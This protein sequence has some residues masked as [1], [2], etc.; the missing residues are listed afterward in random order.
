MITLA[1]AGVLIWRIVLF[2]GIFTENQETQAK[3]SQVSF[4][5]DRGRVDFVYTYQGQRYISGI[6][7]M[8][9]RRTKALR[10]GEDVIVLVDPS[11]PK[12]AIIRKLYS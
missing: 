5:R 10:V 2:R 9:T 4:F 11:C 8:K 12:R 7:I 6:P 1:S 3:I